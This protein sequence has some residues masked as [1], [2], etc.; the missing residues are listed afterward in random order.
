MEQNGA[1]QNRAEQKVVDNPAGGGGVARPEES[2]E[3]PDEEGVPDDRAQRRIRAYGN[4]RVGESGASNPKKDRSE[5][6]RASGES[7]GAR[8]R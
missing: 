5:L 8:G 4:L 3:Q 6:R 1:E 7:E 2:G